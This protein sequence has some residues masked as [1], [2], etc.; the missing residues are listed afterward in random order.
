MAFIPSSLFFFYT[1]PIHNDAFPTL[2]FDF[3]KPLAVGFLFYS[4]AFGCMAGRANGEW[5]PGGE[6][7][8][9][10]LRGFSIRDLH[11]RDFRRHPKHIPFFI[12]TAEYLA[13]KHHFAV[14]TDHFHGTYPD[15]NQK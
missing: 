4:H 15:A 7:L 9:L 1:I 14:F 10:C 3:R 11:T 2:C 13:G 6:I 12:R 8:E 5:K